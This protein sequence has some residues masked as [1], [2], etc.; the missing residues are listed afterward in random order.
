MGVG[1]SGVYSGLVGS[2]G[3]QGPEGFRWHWGLLGDFRGVG[4]SGG[5]Q[6]CQGCIGGIRSPL[7]GIRVCRGCKWCI[8]GLAGSVAT[9]GQEGYRWHK[10]T[11]GASR[12]VGGIW[13]GKW[14]GSLTT[15][16]LGPGSQHSNWFPL[17][18]AYLAKAK[19]VTEMSSAG[20][21]THLELYFMTVCTFVSMP[22]HQHILTHN[23][24]KCYM[25]YFLCRPIYTYPYTINLTYYNTM[26]LIM[27]NILFSSNI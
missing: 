22:S 3:T 4:A 20:Y 24:K 19:Q 26:V 9:Q 25:D 12:G 7:G 5:C 10:G 1:V 27:K 15:L 2:V 17:G 6:G 13:G 16:G 11:L 8:W 18:V 23:V 14:T 21:Y